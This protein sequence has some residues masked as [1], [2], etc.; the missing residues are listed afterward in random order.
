MLEELKNYT[1]SKSKIQHIS[2]K[3]LGILKILSKLKILPV[4]PFQL[5]VMHKDYYFDDKLLLSTG[6]N[7]KYETYF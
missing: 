3:Y 6:F 4:T 5:S 2:I 1:K 7:Y